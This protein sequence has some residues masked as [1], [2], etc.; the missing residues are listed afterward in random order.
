MATRSDGADIQATTPLT[1]ALDAISRAHTL[2]DLTRLVVE[3]A[4]VLLRADGATFMVCED[5]LCHYI[6]ESAVEPLFGDLKVPRAHC[7]GGWVMA[8]QCTAVVT[9]LA[10]ESRLRPEDYA[11]TWVR[12]LVMAPIGSERVFGGLGAY[13]R[14]QHEPTAVEV[15][16]LEILAHAAAAAVENLDLHDAL[17]QRSGERDAAARRR[18]E[19]E[20]G[21]HAIAHDLRAPLGAIAVYAELMARL[22]ADD[23][24]DAEIDTERARAI[25]QTI[26][27]V[28]LRL[29][30]QIDRM[31]GLYRFTQAEIEPVDVDV[32]A[33]ASAIGAT[34]K[35]RYGVPA[36][37]DVT[38]NIVVHADAILV[39]LLVRNLLDN[40]LKYSSKEPVPRIDVD[41]VRDDGQMLTFLV[42]DNGVG[43]DEQAA[44]DLFLPLTRVGDP[45]AFGGDGLGL[46][47]VARVVQRHGGSIR[48][49]SHVGQ[50]A[51]FYITLPSARGGELAPLHPV[52]G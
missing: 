7:I 41:L 10:S 39:R 16:D 31:L 24:P 26:S 29:T 3:A 47:S 36:E 18:D 49:E 37:I 28:S 27:D 33:L 51:V 6:D 42:R 46:S 19:L 20:L 25:A 1:P 52:T 45:G 50:G 4:R 40:A 44:T 21:V 43:F 23:G 13:W 48:A 9:N 8:Q 30:T 32:S 34:Q 17:V 38:D 2:T 5:D 12:S 35:E 15:R 11:D 22:L 14:T